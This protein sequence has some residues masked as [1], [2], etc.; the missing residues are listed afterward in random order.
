MACAL[1]TEQARGEHNGTNSLI[2]QC[3]L[4]GPEDQLIRS[5]AAINTFKDNYSLNHI[6]IT[7]QK[8]RSYLEVR[9]PRLH[10]KYQIVKAA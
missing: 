2:Q 6:C 3:P 5:K 8:F 7:T 1:P 4:A 9:T 10:F